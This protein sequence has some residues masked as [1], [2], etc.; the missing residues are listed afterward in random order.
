MNYK[1]FEVIPSLSLF[2]HLIIYQKELSTISYHVM[3]QYLCCAQ[4]I[5]FLTTLTLL[6][7]L[8]QSTTVQKIPNKRI[9]LFI[10]YWNICHYYIKKHT[11]F[12]CE[13][14]KPESRWEETK[15]KHRILQATKIINMR[16][17]WGSSHQQHSFGSRCVIWNSPVNMSWSAFTALHWTCSSLCWP[18]L[19]P[20]QTLA[21]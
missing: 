8:Q 3:K 5:N 12:Y 1:H 15:L 21:R 20:A 19:N 2:T 13:K 17:S 7:Q 10:I 6:F 9:K 16:T 18:S 4:L 14:V 11:G